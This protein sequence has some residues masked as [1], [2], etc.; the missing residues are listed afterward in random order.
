VCQSRRT[1]V[2]ERAPAKSWP[3][4][5]SCSETAF[6]YLCLLPQLL[7]RFGVPLA[8]FGDH[9]G[10]FVRTDHGWTVQEQLAGKR[11]PT[12]FGRALEQLGITLI[13]ANSPQA[14]G[15]VECLWGVLEDRFISELRLAQAADSN[16][17][18][19]VLREFI[20]A[21]NRPFARQ[22]RETATAWRP[23]P[24]NLERI[25]SNDN[26]VQWEGHHFQI[27][28]QARRFSFASAKV[29]I[30]QALDGRVAFYYGDTRLQHSVMPGGTDSFFRWA[31]E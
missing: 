25:V 12:Q 22:P 19:A 21:Y 13:A 27:L 28:Q 24:E 31:T 11:Q 6:G 29:Q 5:S 23:G 10:I 16:A 30:Y 3:H 1:P 14:K 18:K 2:P 20:A 9:S 8:F 17:A 26:V 15:R 7:R 4:N